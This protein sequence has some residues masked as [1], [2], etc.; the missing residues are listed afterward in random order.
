MAIAVVSHK[1]KTFGFSKIGS[2]VDASGVEI[3]VAAVAGKSHYIRRID[4]YCVA[5]IT[6]TIQDDTGT[7]VVIV[8]GV[9]F[10]GT[11]APYTIEFINPIKV[12]AGNTIDV[13]ASAGGAVAVLVQGFTQ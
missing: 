9:L 11:S 5:A 2:S 10:A 8:P 1:V 12:T 7:P 13:L 6:I 3:I 4:I